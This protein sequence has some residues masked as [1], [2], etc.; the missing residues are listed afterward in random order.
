MDAETAREAFSPLLEIDRST[1][2]SGEEERAVGLRIIN[3]G[4]PHSREQ[5]VRA[6][7]HLVAD[8]AGRY[9]GRGLTPARLVEEGNVGLLRAVEEFD[10]EQGARFSTH[11]TWWIKHC[12][13][14]ALRN[15]P[16]RPGPRLAVLASLLAN[17]AEP[18]PS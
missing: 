4:C 9:L 5:L 15:A 3:Q 17:R 7:I 18:H 1:P 10:P 12:I 11:A 14:Q 2:M 8:I 6:N 13:K 16:S